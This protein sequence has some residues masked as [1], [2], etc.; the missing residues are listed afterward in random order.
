MR[1]PITGVIVA[2][3]AFFQD[4]QKRALERAIKMAGLELKLLIEEPTAVAIAYNAER[5]LNDSNIMIFDFGGG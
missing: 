4:N 2:I 5:K 3:P 1:E